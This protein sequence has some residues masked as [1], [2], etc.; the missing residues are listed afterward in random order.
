MLLI[1]VPYWIILATINFGVL[2]TP[3][4]HE[5]IFYKQFSTKVKCSK[6]RQQG[7]ERSISVTNMWYREYKIR[8][9]NIYLTLHYRKENGIS[10][11][12]T[13]CPLRL[14]SSTT[15]IDMHWKT[16]AIHLHPL[17]S[18]ARISTLIA[19]FYYSR[20]RMGTLK[21]RNFLSH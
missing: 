9:R 17:K 2:Q 1:C 10:D 18:V 4:C 14:S 13:R 15:F 5:R 8:W 20:M 6:H 7:V 11:I 19:I 21:H 3:Q 12:T 16:Q